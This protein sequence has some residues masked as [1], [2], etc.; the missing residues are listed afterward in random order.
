MRLYIPLVH[1][2]RVKLALDDH[3][4][5][6]EPFSQITLLVLEVFGDVADSVGLLAELLGHEV[7]VKQGGVFSHSVGCC[8]YCGEDLVLHLNLPY[9]L[10]GH[11][12]VQCGYSGYRVPLEQDLLPGHDVR[13]GGISG[14]W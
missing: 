2:R 8:Q 4:R 13:P 7:V 14:W 1:R 12:Q 11:V 5:L 9:G 3:V 10:L 6:C